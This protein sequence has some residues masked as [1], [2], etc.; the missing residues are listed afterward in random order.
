M[1]C[2]PIFKE[3]FPNIR[4]NA[5]T[6]IHNK[7]IIIGCLE[8]SNCMKHWGTRSWCDNLPDFQVHTPGKIRLLLRNPKCFEILENSCLKKLVPTY[9]FLVYDFFDLGLLYF[10]K[11]LLLKFWNKK[12]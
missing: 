2:L 8:Y 6:Q 10:L 5:Q 4:W 7:T 1:P 9:E 12:K 11:R 3:I